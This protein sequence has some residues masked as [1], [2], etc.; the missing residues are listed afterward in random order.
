VK[1]LFTIDGLG[2]G[3]AERSLY[4][5]LPGLVQRGIEPTVVCLH[6]RAEGVERQAVGDGLDVR[7]LRS[8]RTP[9]RIREVRAML[10][11]ERPDL[12]HTAIFEASLVGRSAAAGLGVPVLSTLVSMPYGPA[13]MRDPRVG[14]PSLAAVRAADRF[15]A[16]HLTTHFHAITEAVK[17][18]A[19]E[20]LGVPPERITVI[21]RG[22]DPRRLGMPGPDRRRRARAALE[23]G[24]SSRRGSGT[25]WRPWPRWRGAAPAWSC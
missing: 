15:T 25:W 7:F 6:H 19:V 9:G 14:R 12:V 3:G 10:R 2:T 8:R 13:R 17:A 16:R 20:G 23:L 18:W 24:R 5:S 1:V 21:H 22:R 11:R 4:E